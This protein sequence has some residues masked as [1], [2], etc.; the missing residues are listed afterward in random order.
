MR[1]QRTARD[2]PTIN[3]TPLIDVLFLV[4]MF[5]VLTATFRGAFVIDLTL[6]TAQSGTPA[7]VTAP[8]VVRVVLSQDG[9]VTVEERRLTLDE[10]ERLLTSLP[11][12]ETLQVVLSA[13]GR[14][15]HAGVVAVVDRVR[16][17]GILGL[18][19]ETIPRALDPA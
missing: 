6:P 19:I 1:F 15:P 17:A 5:L 8:G 12:R 10:L 13:D 3:L 16:R 18:R 9:Q 11:D 14:T 7:S 2:L 4:L